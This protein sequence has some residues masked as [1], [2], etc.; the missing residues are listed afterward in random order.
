[1]VVFKGLQRRKRTGG[2]IREL[3]GDFLEQDQLEIH[4]TLLERGIF[5]YVYCGFL[6]SFNRY[7]FLLFFFVDSQMIFVAWE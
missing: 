5:R 6:I 1:M 4:H 3:S 2:A 7:T